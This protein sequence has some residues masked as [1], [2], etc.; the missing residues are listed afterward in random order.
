MAVWLALAV[1]IGSTALPRIDELGLYYDEAFLAQQA[2]GFVV[3]DRAGMHPG[4][5]RSVE[6]FGRPFPLRNAA[7]L[8]SLKSQLLIPSL[9]LAGSDL[10]VVRATTL[11]TGLLALLLSMLWARRVFGLPTALVAGLLVASDPSFY[12]LS[13]FEWGPFTTN[14]LCRAGGL[15][16]LTIAWQ[17][18]RPRRALMAA[19]GGG[20]LFGLG[21]FSRA[22]FAVILAAGGLALAICHLDLVRSALRERLPLVLAAGA[23]LLLA[24]SPMLLSALQLIGASATIAERGDLGDKALVLWSVLDG[25]HFHRLM[26]VGG[27][28]ER[29]HEVDAPWSPFGAVLVLC[30][31]ALAVQLVRRRR[32]DA[33][34]SEPDGRAFLFTISVI[35][36]GAMLLVPGAVRAHHQLNSLPFLQLLVAS[37]IVALWHR[38]RAQ[39][40]GALLARS[41][42]GLT[43]SAILLGNIAVIAQTQQLI[44]ETGGRG[45]WS[46]ALNGFAA[47]ADNEAGSLVV[48]LDWGFHE[49][50]LFLSSRAKMIEPIWG[51]A[52]VLQSGRPWVFEGT[53]QMIYLVHAAPYDLFGLS[54]RFLRAARRLGPDGAQIAAHTDRQGEAAFYSVRI[55]RQHRLVYTGRFQI[56]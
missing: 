37:A 10:R 43:L 15:L 33:A 47:A 16:L 35:L 51:I 8:G 56:D 27:V 25:S 3:P 20:A 54:S 39:P 21:V 32:A 50:L 36:S 26:Q 31:T 48:S 53:S 23:T 13:Q 44:S 42:A 17:S 5:V 1:L 18:E 22:D 4:S 30:S 14:L 24:A 41:L 40:R 2:R 7:Y 29:I 38:G 46:Q 19:L 12:F 6:L 9:A 52:G 45:R 11:A 55:P 49:P 28:F 34:E